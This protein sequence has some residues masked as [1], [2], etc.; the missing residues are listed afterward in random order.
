[1]STDR[2]FE[3]ALRSLTLGRWECREFPAFSDYIRTYDLR[4]TDTAPHISVDSLESLS[5]VLREAETMVLRLGQSQDGRGTRFALVATPGRLRDFFLIDE[6]I[7]STDPSTPVRLAVD[8]EMLLPYS[9]LPKLTE[10]MAV[11]LA[12]ASGLMGHAL[13]LDSP[14]F[15]GAPVRGSATYSF[16]F[17]P[18]RGADPVEHRRGQVEIDALLAGRRD[19]RPVLF[20][21]EF[22]MDSSRSLAKHKLLYPLLAMAPRVPAGKEMVPVYVRVGRHGGRVVYDVVECACLD[23]REGTVCLTELEARAHRRLEI[24]LGER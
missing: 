15:T 6:E 11:S 18:Y 21:C 23:P 22:K 9:M 5:P 4:A 3:P 19:G 16:A 1:M 13:G 12:F 2:V 10:D 20:V 24:G 17:R 14:F 7:I 8:E